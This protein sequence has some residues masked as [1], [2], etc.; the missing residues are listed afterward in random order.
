MDIKEICKQVT[1]KRI[2]LYNECEQFLKLCFSQIDE[3]EIK[4][5]YLKIIDCVIEQL[6]EKCAPYFINYEFRKE[7]KDHL[8][9]ID[10]N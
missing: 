3:C 8:F 1:Q 9:W 5:D 6:N 2:N 7:K 4:D 10:T